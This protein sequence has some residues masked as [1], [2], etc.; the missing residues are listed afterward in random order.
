MN[1]NSERT[2]L[3]AALLERNKDLERS[4]AAL[5]DQL[6]ETVAHNSK[7]RQARQELA[8]EVHLLRGDNANLTDQLAAMTIDRESKRKVAE[9]ASG[10]ALEAFARNDNF[11]VTL[12]KVAHALVEVVRRNVPQNIRA[13]WDRYAAQPE[14]PQTTVAYNTDTGV[15]LWAVG[16]EGTDFWLAAFS[17]EVEARGFNIAWRVPHR[18]PSPFNDILE[19]MDA[20][21]ERIHDLDANLTAT[22]GTIHQLFEIMAEPGECNI[23]DVAKRVVAERDKGKGKGS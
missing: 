16:I 3:E 12:Q 2:P 4:I 8:V 1:T 11:K 17:T 21:A 22:K 5:N 10:Q 23:I 19:H 14:R 7:L 20:Q 9:Q 13:E 18:N 6:A 15:P